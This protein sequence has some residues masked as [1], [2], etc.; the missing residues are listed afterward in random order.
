MAQQKGYAGQIKNQ[1]AQVV[2]GPYAQQGAK[3]TDKTKSGNDL[4]TNKG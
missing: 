3:G 2:K 4:R 1:G